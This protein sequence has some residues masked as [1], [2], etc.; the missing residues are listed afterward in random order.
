MRRKILDPSP[1]PIGRALNEIGDWWTLLIVREAFHGATRFRD[2]ERLPISKNILS[3]RLKLLLEAGI[4]ELES[5]DEAGRAVSTYRL[6][7]K[8][9]KL[10]MV[11]VSLR[12]WGEEFLFD[13]GE[14]MSWLLDPAGQPVKRLR[15]QAS[16]GTDLTR[17]Q[18][19]LEVRQVTVSAGK[20]Q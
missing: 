3:I 10:W 5:S 2:F 8:G 18:T 12:Q 9:E 4:F 19:R 17:R 20:P 16:D 14:E 13:E 1:C 7:E 15:V 6:T 11:L